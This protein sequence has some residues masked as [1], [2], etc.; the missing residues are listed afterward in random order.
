MQTYEYVIYLFCRLILLSIRYYV[1]SFT[2]FVEKKT[3]IV[4]LK[5]YVLDVVKY[6]CVSF[7]NQILSFSHNIRTCTIHLCMC[8]YVYVLYCIMYCIII[9]TFTC[10]FRIKCSSNHVFRPTMSA[11]MVDRRKLVVVG[12]GACGKT[13][14]LIVF[15]KNQ[16][17]EVCYL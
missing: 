1:I 3:D 17:P 6:I 14:L 16:F 8:M 9:I 10:K 15:S 7:L 11:Q 4:V 12:D 2:F 5:Y 13:C